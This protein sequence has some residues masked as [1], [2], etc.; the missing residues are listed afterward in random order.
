M[1]FLK[2]VIG[3]HIYPLSEVKI[4]GREEHIVCL[5]HFERR[6]T[7]RNCRTLQARCSDVGTPL[8]KQTVACQKQAVVGYIHLLL[9]DYILQADG[10]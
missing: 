2:P 8:T 7:D 10:L 4:L 6:H 3:L 1:F 9:V 5:P